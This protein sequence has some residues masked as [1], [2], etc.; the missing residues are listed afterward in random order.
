MALPA[1]VAPSTAPAASNWLELVKGYINDGALVLAL[2]ISIVAFIAVAY[3][4]IA[5]FNAARQSKAE[6]GGRRSIALGHFTEIRQPKKGATEWAEVGLLAIVG[7]VLLLVI[8]FLVNEVTSI[9]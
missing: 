2:A 4:A 1:P 6:W 7:A 8:S 9:M 3:G 5:K